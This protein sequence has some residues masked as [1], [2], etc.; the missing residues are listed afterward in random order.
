MF[1]LNSTLLH[2]YLQ[3][4]PFFMYTIYFIYIAKELYVIIE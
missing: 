4:L 1:I 2:Q 3:Y